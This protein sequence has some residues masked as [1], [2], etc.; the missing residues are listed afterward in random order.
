MQDVR[1]AMANKPCGMGLGETIRNLTAL[2]DMLSS[3][4]GALGFALKF[5]GYLALQAS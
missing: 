2:A 5:V 1:D 3:F 4:M